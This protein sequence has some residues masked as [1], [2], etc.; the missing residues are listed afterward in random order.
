MIRW[1]PKN[2]GMGIEGQLSI[3]QRHKKKRKRSILEGIVETIRLTSRRLTM[4]ASGGSTP[5]PTS[6]VVVFQ[7]SM[8]VVRDSHDDEISNYFL[9]IGSSM[10]FVHSP[11]YYQII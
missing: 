9:T 3:E 2:G 11:S 8:V 4:P 5:L 6:Q 1:M 10:P 7:G